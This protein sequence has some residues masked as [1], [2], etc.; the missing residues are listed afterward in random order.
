MLGI[1]LVFNPFDGKQVLT[2]MM[3][4]SLIVDGVQNLCTVV[5]AAVFVKDVKNAVHDFVDNATA[6]E[7]TGEVI[8][9]DDA[10]SRP[11]DGPKA[12]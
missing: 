12:P 8:G 4:V 10:G 3:G 11:D 7:T 9:E 1:L 6:V 5:Y 2:I